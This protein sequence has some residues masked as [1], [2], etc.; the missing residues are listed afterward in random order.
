MVEKECEI[1]GCFFYHIEMAL[2]LYNTRIFRVL[3]KS[4]FTLVYVHRVNLW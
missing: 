2:N 3:K 1:A 4:K